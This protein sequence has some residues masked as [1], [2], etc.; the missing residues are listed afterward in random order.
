MTTIV[1][2]MRKVAS[3]FSPLI[4]IDRRERKPLHRQIYEGYRKAILRC[5]LGA[6]QQVPSSRQLASEL[7]I[8]R[9]PV[10]NAY[11]QLLA[12]G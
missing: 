2:V 9:I 10:L 1:V 11:A 8:S 6:G 12:E 4:V 7:G 5:S 3:G